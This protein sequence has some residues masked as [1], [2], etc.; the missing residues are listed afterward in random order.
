MTACALIPNV[1]DELFKE[2]ASQAVFLLF[3]SLLCTAGSQR[4]PTK[5]GFTHFKKKA[6]SFLFWHELNQYFSLPVS[7]NTFHRLPYLFL[8]PKSSV[9]ARCPILPPTHFTLLTSLPPPLTL[10]R[11]P[12]VR[13]QV[14][15]YCWHISLIPSS[16][17]SCNNFYHSYSFFPPFF[18]FWTIA[19]DRRWTPPP[20]QCWT[21]WQRPPSI[22]SRTQVTLTVCA[23]SDAAYVFG[24][25]TVTYITRVI[26]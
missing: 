14:S 11:P 1:L 7:R 9:E 6:Y 16:S 18:S 12:T 26:Q 10:F 24:K 21:L 13:W 5:A 4:L 25:I 20:G 22:C 23:W 2:N 17:S 8:K 15:V 19:V 3:V